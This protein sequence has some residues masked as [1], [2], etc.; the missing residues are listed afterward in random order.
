M[1]LKNG[2]KD[3]FYD[4]ETAYQSSLTMM[5]HVKEAESISQFFNFSEGQ[6][7][8]H[9]VAKINFVRATFQ[10]FGAL[11]DSIRK[12]AEASINCCIIYLKS[13]HLHEH[14]IIK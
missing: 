7:S 2:K 12:N 11:C 3:V 13:K 10:K 5:H 14:C 9:S 4:L 8:C 1:M 6:E